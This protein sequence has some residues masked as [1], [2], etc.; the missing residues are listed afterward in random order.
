MSEHLRRKDTL[1][2]FTQPSFGMCKVHPSSG[3]VPDGGEKTGSNLPPPPPP[4][5][6]PP[7]TVCRLA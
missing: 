5:L 7:P 6:P 1:S 2:I 3:V 4:P